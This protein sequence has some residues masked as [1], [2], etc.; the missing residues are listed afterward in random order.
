MW[1]HTPLT[2]EQRAW[3]TQ[4]LTSCSWGSLGCYHATNLTLSWRLP[5]ALACIGPLGVLAGVFFVP[6]MMNEISSSSK[7]FP[8]MECTNEVNLE[9]PRF[10]VWQG[11]REQAWDILKRLHHDPSSPSDADARAE[12]TQ[13]V[14][15]FE[16]DKEDTVTFLKMFQKPSWRR[17]SISVLLLL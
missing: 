4:L 3:L 14:R 1:S 11:K 9:S 10:L 15:Q 8:A 13:I 7:L 16:L 17:R 6:G 12:F 2:T 5:L